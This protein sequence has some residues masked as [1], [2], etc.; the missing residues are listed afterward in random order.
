LHKHFKVTPK[1]FRQ[2]LTTHGFP[3]SE[4]EVN[5]VALVYG[6]E[7]GEI[8]YAEFLKDCNVLKFEIYGPTTLAKSTYTPKFIDYN[9]E[10]EFQ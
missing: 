9:G 2:V 8:K 5:C 7:T 4:E 1:I 3:L 6:S 10:R